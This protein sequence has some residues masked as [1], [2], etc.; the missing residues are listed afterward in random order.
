MEAL[1]RA[2]WAV[3]VL[4]ITAVLIV[5]GYGAYW[6]LA[7]NNAQKQY[8]VN[9]NTQQWQSSKIDQLRNLSHDWGVAQDPGQKQVIGSQFCSIYQ[10]VNP[11]PPANGTADLFTVH[12]TICN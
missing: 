12:S 8:E 9:T 2:S 7:K 10:L 11:L 1:S 4:A 3:A 6:W 5:G